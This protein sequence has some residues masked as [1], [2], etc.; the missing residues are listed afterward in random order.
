MKKIM[1]LIALSLLIVSCGGGGGSNGGGEKDLFS[2]WNRTTDNSPLELTGG[3]FSTNIG[4]SFFF[5]GGAQ[6]DCDFAVLGT[7]S[8]GTYVVNSCFY[9]FGS[10]SGDP[11]CNA[12]N[13]TGIYTNSNNTLT[14]TGPNGTSIYQ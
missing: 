5:V 11:G 14:I 4:I 10:G 8:S 2:L 3:T 12:L 1:S 6:C 9:R 13:Q 7:Q